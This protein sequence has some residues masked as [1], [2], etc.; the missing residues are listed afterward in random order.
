[1]S[2]KN[3]L[4]CKNKRR[5]ST[6]NLLQCKEKKRDESIDVWGNKKPPIFFMIEK[7]RVSKKQRS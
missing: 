7:L 3:K 1:L 2:G 4:F 6:E 5:K